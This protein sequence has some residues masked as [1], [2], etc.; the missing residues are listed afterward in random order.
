MSRRDVNQYFTESFTYDSVYRLNEARLSG[1]VT[2]TMTYKRHRKHHQQGDA[3]GN[4][5]LLVCGGNR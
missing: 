5:G 2:L 4:V 1:V 3:R